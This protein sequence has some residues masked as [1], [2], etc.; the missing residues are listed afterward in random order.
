MLK[1]YKLWVGLLYTMNITA[2]NAIY[3][4][5]ITGISSLF[6][7]LLFYLWLRKDLLPNLGHSF[8]TSHSTR[9]TVSLTGRVH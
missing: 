8:Q 7:L 1:D 9:F 4:H 6:I 2:F 3:G 5:Y